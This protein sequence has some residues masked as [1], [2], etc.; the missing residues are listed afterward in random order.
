MKQ[1]YTAFAPLRKEIIEKYG[2]VRARIN[3]TSEIE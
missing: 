2:G 3:R 1:R